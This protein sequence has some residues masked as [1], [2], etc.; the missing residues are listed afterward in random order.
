MFMLQTLAAVKQNIDTKSLFL[1]L[2]VMVIQKPRRVS[3]NGTIRGKNSM[4]HQATNHLQPHAFLF[5]CAAAARE[6]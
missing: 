3:R 6:Q 4:V 2:N 5:L 1:S